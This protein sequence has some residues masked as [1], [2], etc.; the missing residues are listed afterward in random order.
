MRKRNW[1]IAGGLIGT[2]LL[3]WSLAPRP[4]ASDERAL[5]RMTVASERARRACVA[6]LT[7]VD[8]SGGTYG[9]A[10]AHPYQ[11]LRQLNEIDY[12]AQARSVRLIADA[13]IDAG[14]VTRFSAEP[15]CYGKTVLQTPRIVGRFGFVNFRHEVSVGLYSGSRHGTY[16]YL[17]SARGWQP[18]AYKQ[19]DGGLVY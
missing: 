15:R 18:L 17:R 16:A 7:S 11:E 1:V 14:S 6:F 4:A 3:L 2:G 13:N 12:R 19:T 8:V 9:F 10:N 5:L